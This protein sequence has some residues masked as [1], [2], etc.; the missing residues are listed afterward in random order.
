[1][2]RLLTSPSACAGAV[3]WNRRKTLCPGRSDSG[4]GWE[5][6]TT[7]HPEGALNSTVPFATG[8]FPWLTNVA[9]A[10]N[11]FPGSTATGAVSPA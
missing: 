7:F 11:V 5:N 2:V 3:T 9:F 8:W 4:R 1:M 10:V 6:G